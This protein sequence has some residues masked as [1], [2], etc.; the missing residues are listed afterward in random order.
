MNSPSITHTIVRTTHP[1]NGGVGSA[2]SPRGTG[3]YWHGKA[4][5]CVPQC[6]LTGVC[7]RIH[8]ACVH[9]QQGARGDDV[10]TINYDR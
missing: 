2:Q 7:C 6:S 5:E 10:A 9:V 3:R 4:A 1:P 8:V